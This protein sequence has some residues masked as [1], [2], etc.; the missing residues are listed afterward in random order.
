M[1]ETITIDNLNINTVTIKK[2]RVAEIEGNKYP[3]GTLNTTSYMN[4]IKGR[5]KLQQEVSEQYAKAI[6]TVWGDTP[7]VEE[8]IKDLG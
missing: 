1:Y 7:T 4:S 8:N 6:F 5:N 3:I 2:Q